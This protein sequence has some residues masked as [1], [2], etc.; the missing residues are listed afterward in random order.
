MITTITGVFTMCNYEHVKYIILFNIQDNHI[1]ILQQSKLKQVKQLVQ[2]SHNSQAMDLGHK[3]RPHCKVQ[4][5][6]PYIMLFCNALVL[7]YFS[8]IKYSSNTKCW[9]PCYMGE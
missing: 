7:G 1:T 6:N 2:S 8:F 9:A 3:S 5:L 4:A